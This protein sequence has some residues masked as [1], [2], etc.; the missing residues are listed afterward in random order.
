MRESAPVDTVP[1]DTNVATKNSNN[2]FPNA[3]SLDTL[4]CSGKGVTL[5]SSE[6]SC[7]ECP[8]VTHK[9]SKT[10][11][12]T[13]LEVCITTTETCADSVATCGVAES[14]SNS[15]GTV[16]GLDSSIMA[17]D[18]E[19][20]SRDSCTVDNLTRAF[21]SHRS[22]RHT[23]P[24]VHSNDSKTSKSDT[25]LRSNCSLSCIKEEDES[26]CTSYLVQ[27]ENE[28]LKQKIEELEET[29]ATAEST[30]I[31]QSLMI[32]LYQMDTAS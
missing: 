20:Q 16:Q 13:S 8:G 15:I 7:I 24:C 28:E 23:S 3:K 17:R 19:N 30:V 32:K 6:S 25:N 18:D 31:W 14:E 27:K 10:L 22:W 2:G 11:D 1:F 4:E 29:L 9:L 26:K 12:T 21:E 5:A